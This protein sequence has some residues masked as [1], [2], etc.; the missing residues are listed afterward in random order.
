MLRCG[1]EKSPNHGMIRGCPVFLVSVGSPFS[2]GWRRRF[3]AGL[4][5]PGSTIF[6]A[7]PGFAQWHMVESVP[8]YS[9]G[10][11]LDS[12]EVPFSAFKL[13][14]VRGKHLKQDPTLPIEE[15][16]SNS[17][18][19]AWRGPAPLLPPTAQ[20]SRRRHGVAEYRDNRATNLLRGARLP[21]ATP[22]AV[23]TITVFFLPHGV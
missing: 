16:E 3:Q 20:A 8:G 10:P 18:L 15:R 2:T 1:D 5:T 11:V 19:P 6:H 9:G 14:K 7:F 13:P 12:H 17:F 4:L 21:P 22:R 23:T